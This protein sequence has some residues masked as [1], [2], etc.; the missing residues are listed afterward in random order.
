MVEPK[1]RASSKGARSPA[2]IRA[3][4]WWAIM[5]R[6]WNQSSQDNIGLV[7]AG[8]AFYAF[9]AFV[10]LLAAMV[11]TYGLVAEP[12]SVVTNMKMLTAMVPQDAATLIGDQ[13]SGVVNTAQAKKGFGL[14]LALLFSI[15]GSMNGA[16]G[17]IAALNVAYEVKEQ[18]S[19]VKLTIL[20]IVF[21]VGAVATLILA[22][23]GISAL[24]LVQKLL[25]TTTGAVHVLVK[26]AVW[27]VEAL[28][29]SLIV[30][31]IYRYGPNRPKAPWKWLSPGSVAATLLWV[32]VTLLFGLYVSS[33]GSYN[34]TYGSLGAV[35]VFLTWLYLTAYV[36]LMGAELNSETER[37]AR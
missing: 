2:D 17:L 10:P 37:E 4:G 26:I 27:F 19:F 5:K 22:V 34:A 18:R 3:D 32:A 30:A 24:A 29:V 21:T 12:S 33:F 1:P 11:L 31:L 20:A 7:S 16:S 15:Y 28:A 9:L 35:V 8:V 23:V 14:L 36:L 25:P 6:V 13:L